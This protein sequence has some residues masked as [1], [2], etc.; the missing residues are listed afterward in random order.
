MHIRQRMNN[1]DRKTQRISE[2]YRS[3]LLYEFFDGVTS[4]GSP[5]L[6]IL[7]TSVLW[8]VGETFT[9]K[10]LILGLLISGLIV[11]TIKKSTDRTRPDNHTGLFYSQ[12]SFPSGHSTSAFMTATVLNH[13]YNK[14]AAFFGLATTVA[15]SRVYLEDHYL[16]DIIAGTL[17]GTIVGI[18][19][20]GIQFPA[21]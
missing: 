15:V 18:T 3:G 4:L 7:I 13:S 8:S 6:V 17:I 10:T 19:L 16:T 11:R 20:V 2:K 12:K 14:P 9:A 5:P 1:I 21:L